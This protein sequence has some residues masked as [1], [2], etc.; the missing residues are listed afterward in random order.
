MEQNLASKK[1][2]QI[3]DN[4]MPLVSILIYNYNYGRYLTECFQ[5][6]L[7]QS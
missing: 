4:N 1:L 5:S 6:A 2:P 7:D 3:A